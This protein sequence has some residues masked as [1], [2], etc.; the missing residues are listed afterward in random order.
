MRNLGF[1]NFNVGK[2][3]S[4]LSAILNR[5]ELA[6]GCLPMFVVLLASVSWKLSVC[7]SKECFLS[8]HTHLSHLFGWLQLDYF[9]CWTKLDLKGCWW[10]S[11]WKLCW[12]LARAR[13]CWK[14]LHCIL[15]VQLCESICRAVPCSLKS[16]AFMYF[17][18]DCKMKINYLKLLC[19]FSL[20]PCCIALVLCIVHYLSLLQSLG[21]GHFHHWEVLRAVYL[22]G[23]GSDYIC[24]TSTLGGCMLQ[25]NVRNQQVVLQ[26]LMLWVFWYPLSSTY[27]EIIH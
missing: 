19:D 12:I 21:F 6:Y 8:W 24:S 20:F 16:V 18:Q 27:M 4:I 3:F 23:G 1:V 10:L 5:N 13:L 7:L 25:G 9:S 15:A 14:N 17:A 2:C 11:P 22:T 26:N